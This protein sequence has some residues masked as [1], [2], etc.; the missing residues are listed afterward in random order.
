[1]FF[2]DIVARGKVAPDWEENVK[3]WTL[4]FIKKKPLYRLPGETMLTEHRLRKIKQH[5]GV[6]SYLE[7]NCL[8]PDLQ[9]A[10]PKYPHYLEERRRLRAS[11]RHPANPIQEEAYTKCQERN[12][13]WMTDLDQGRFEDHAFETNVIWGK[14]LIRNEKGVDYIKRQPEVVDFGHKE[15]HFSPSYE[16]VPPGILQYDPDYPEET[17]EGTVWPM[18]CTVRTCYFCGHRQV[19][20][21]LWVYGSLST[22][23]TPREAD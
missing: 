5:W 22:S 21:C 14:V 4:L 2:G 8:P 7:W 6:L 3:I 12:H 17:P 18:S 1:M 11:E 19:L 15:N 9:Q 13:S 10:H 20:Q 16:V 23:F